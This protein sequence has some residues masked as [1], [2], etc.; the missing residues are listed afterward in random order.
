M[1]ESLTKGTTA[2][3]TIKTFGRRNDGRGAF[4]ALSNAFM[5]DDVKR[6]LMKR[7]ELTLAH[8]VFDGKSR[9]WTFP[10]H[11]SRLRESFNDMEESG[12]TYTEQMKVSKVAQLSQLSSPGPSTSY[13]RSY[14]Q[15]PS[16]F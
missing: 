12:N 2:W 15:M 16:K 9:N 3:N 5:G 14:P 7:A 13:H 1:L 4:W 8:A 11:I 6:L 10:H